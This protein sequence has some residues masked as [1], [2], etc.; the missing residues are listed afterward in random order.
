MS[1]PE[2]QADVGGVVTEV[3][4]TVDGLLRVVPIVGQLPGVPQ[5]P[6]LSGV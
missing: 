2:P 5:L 3:V 1:A 6:A 4:T